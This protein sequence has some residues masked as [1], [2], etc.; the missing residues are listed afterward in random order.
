VSEDADALELGMRQKS[1][2]FLHQ[3]ARVYLPVVKREHPVA[4]NG[5]VGASIQS[6]RHQ[7]RIRGILESAPGSPGSV[8]ADSSGIAS[9]NA[10]PASLFLYKTEAVV[11]AIIKI[12]LV[13]PEGC[14]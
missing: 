13:G 11:Q 2:E 4:P 12:G 9:R 3:G 7:L 6:S 10:G 14:P 5:P 1:A 8:D